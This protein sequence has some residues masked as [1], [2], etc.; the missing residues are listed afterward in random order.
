MNWEKIEQN[1][2]KRKAAYIHKSYFHCIY[3]VLAGF[4]IIMGLSIAI[5][6]RVG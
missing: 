6:V 2:G 5:I 4:V 3:I 1:I